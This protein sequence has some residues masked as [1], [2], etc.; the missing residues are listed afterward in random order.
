VASVEPGSAAE[1]AGLRPGDYLLR[2]G[3]VPVQDQTF[4]A[5]FRARYQRGDVSQV[6][7]QIRRDG[8]PMTVQ[9]PIRFAAREVRGLVYESNPTPKAARIRDG[10]LRGTTGR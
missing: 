9:L 3:E 4:G 6:P 7:T 2:V 10:I 1:E 5:R 8:E